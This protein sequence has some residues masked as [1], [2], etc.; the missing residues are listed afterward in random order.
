METEMGRVFATA[1]IE[2]LL[3]LGE[4]DRGSR[5]ADQV[6]RIVVSNALVDTGATATCLANAPDR[7]ARLKKGL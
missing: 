1:T 2:N 7:A 6:R 4:V 5:P 3:D